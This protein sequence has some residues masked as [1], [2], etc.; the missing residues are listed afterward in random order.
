MEKDQFDFVESRLAIA[1]AGG[2]VEEI[3]LDL[4]KEWYKL[5]DDAGKKNELEISEFLKDVSAIAN[6]YGGGDGYIIIGV[7]ELKGNKGVEFFESNLTDSGYDDESDF[8]NLLKSRI[9]KV[10]NIQ[11]LDHTFTIDEAERKVSIV[12]I[13]PSISK[14]HVVVEYRNRNNQVFKN[15]VFIRIGGT[16]EIASKADFDRM[17][18]E[19]PTIQTE[20]EIELNI[21]LRDLKF[22]V[23]ESHNFHNMYSVQCIFPYGVSLEN[24]GYR[25]ITFNKVEIKFDFEFEPTSLFF[26]KRYTPLKFIREEK[27]L[28]IKPNLNLIYDEYYLTF[29]RPLDHEIAQELAK[30]LNNQIESITIVQGTIYLAKGTKLPCK[31][32][33]VKD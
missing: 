33:V 1:A 19:R 10:F 32:N 29:N 18:L 6:S 24:L 23:N 5:R 14:P 12:Y 2:S 9:D 11:I 26:S 20:S 28:R 8:I 4:K 27:Y 25:L 21:Q 22:R 16:N 15:E 17:Y 13:P 3:K 30:L 7:K 31:L